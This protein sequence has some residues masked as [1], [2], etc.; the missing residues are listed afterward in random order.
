[1]FYYSRFRAWAMR[2]RAWVSCCLGQAKFSRWKPS[3]SPLGPN[4]A[5]SSVATRALWHIKSHSCAWSMP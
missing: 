2:S 4:L 1:M 3:P 5:P